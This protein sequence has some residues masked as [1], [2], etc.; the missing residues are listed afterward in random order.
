MICLL[1]LP[2]SFLHMMNV[3]VINV[4]YEEERREEGK[5]WWG[6]SKKGPK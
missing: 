5:W 6:V 2:L 4:F 3:I 1:L